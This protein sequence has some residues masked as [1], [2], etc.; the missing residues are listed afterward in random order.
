[1]LIKKNKLKGIPLPGGLS[2]PLT[3][4]YWLPVVGQGDYR[5]D[6]SNCIQDWR[7]AGANL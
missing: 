1:M 7:A 3:V 5:G 2:E 4:R 6:L